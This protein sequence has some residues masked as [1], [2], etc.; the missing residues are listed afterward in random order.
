MLSL[1]RPSYSPILSNS[2]SL[3]HSTA[4]QV[5][6]RGVCLPSQTI[7][8]RAAPEPLILPLARHNYLFAPPGNP[9][10]RWPLYA[11]H[12]A[13]VYHQPAAP[14]A[15]IPCAIKSKQKPALQG[16]WA[17]DAGLTSTTSS[18]DLG[19]STTTLTCASFYRHHH[20]LAHSSPVAT[21][22]HSHHVEGHSKCQKCHQGVF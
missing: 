22:S 13:Q 1:A 2:S 7:R 21:D 3:W 15:R 14:T 11:D 5:Y 9:P 8:L 19:A 6:F 17:G 18:I 20:F 12:L 10:T 16:D 4:G